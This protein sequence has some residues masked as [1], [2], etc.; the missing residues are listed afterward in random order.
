MKI[1]YY[2]PSDYSQLIKLYQT[3]GEF[4]VDEITDSED[5][6]KRKI[7]RDPKSI[8]LAEENGELLGSVS[9]IEDGRIALLFRFVAKGSN[10][11]KENISKQILHE[12]ESLLK[13]RG[14]EE[15]HNTVPLDDLTALTEKEGIGFTKGNA[16][17]WFWKKIG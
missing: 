5:N 12:A 17:M 1:R 2:L 16:Y 10:E 14:Y 3:S 15:V 13:D 8:L 11:E 7:E 9:I 6:I 4:K